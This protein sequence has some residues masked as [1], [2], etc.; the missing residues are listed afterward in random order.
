MFGQEA[1]A[2]QDWR[3]A[4]GLPIQYEPP[5]AEIAHGVHI[6]PDDGDNLHDDAL[7]QPGVSSDTP[8]AACSSG[9]RDQIATACMASEVI[10]CAVS[11]K[12]DDVSAQLP[13]RKTAGAAGFDLYPLHDVVVPPDDTI[14]IDTGL[15]MAIPTGSVGIVKGRSSVE[16][17]GVY[18]VA[19]VID[20]DFRGRVQVVMRNSR[21]TP[22]KF[23]AGNAIAQ[24][25]IQRCSIV[26][27]CEVTNLDYTA[28][29]EGGF[30]PTDRKA[31]HY[32]ETLSDSDSSAESHPI[33]SFPFAV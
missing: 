8:V 7:A 18:V 26:P 13:V 16:Q 23:N 21:T 24:L 14:R 17:Q 2:Y 25:L 30:G 29:G 6:G 10:D 31:L 20:S 32:E 5:E 1:V 19:G 15:M 12:R 9:G 33:V 22:W 11:V 3:A 27:M 4:N 28:R